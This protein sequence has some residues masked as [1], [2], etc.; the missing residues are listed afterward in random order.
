MLNLQPLIYCAACRNDIAAGCKLVYILW[1]CAA[2]TSV[3]QELS[4]LAESDASGRLRNAS[5][6]RK[7]GVTASAGVSQGSTTRVGVRPGLVCCGG[8]IWP[9][10]CGVRSP[11]H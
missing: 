5:C 3:S 8:G 4:L 1:Q 9:L 2:V 11:L 7:E 10:L 6:N